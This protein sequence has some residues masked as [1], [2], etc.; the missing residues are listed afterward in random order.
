MLQV[1]GDYDYLGVRIS[2]CPPYGETG[3]HEG[4][5]GFFRFVQHTRRNTSSPK[6][7]RLSAEHPGLICCSKRLAFLV[8]LD[9][10]VY[11]FNGVDAG[12]RLALLMR[13]ATKD[14]SER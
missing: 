8:T 1:I 7:S 4:L 11:K 14:R 12:L 10:G 9:S 6:G 2:N 5:A 3:G 13:V